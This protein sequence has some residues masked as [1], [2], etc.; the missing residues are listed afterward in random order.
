MHA[1]LAGLY[2]AWNPQ[3][4]SWSVFGQ[5]HVA[6]VRGARGR[7]AWIE[8][9]GHMCGGKLGCRSVQPCDRSHAPDPHTPLPQVLLNWAPSEGGHGSSEHD[10]VTDA[11]KSVRLFNHYHRLRAQPGAWEAAQQAL[12]AAPPLQS[13]ARRHPTF[14]GVCMG[15]R[16]QCSCGATFFS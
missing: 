13:F 2:R 6:K 9:Q 3:Y 11:V 5:D 15:N 14:E 8:W 10:A 1:D 12:L 16:K 7:E 4:R